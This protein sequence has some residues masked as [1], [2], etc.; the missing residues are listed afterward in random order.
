METQHTCPPLP[1]NPVCKHGNPATLNLAQ[2]CHGN[3][4]II[5]GTM[6]LC[7]RCLLEQSAQ[8]IV[9]K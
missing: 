5:T 4:H 1:P 9:L 6:Q 8:M 2:E 7:Q 3:M